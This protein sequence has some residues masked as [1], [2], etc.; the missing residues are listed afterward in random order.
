MDSL[1]RRGV[2][3]TVPG[4]V[5][6]ATLRFLK[7]N[8]LPDLTDGWVETQHKI[9]LRNFPPARHLVVWRDDCSSL[10]DAIRVSVAR[11]SID[12]VENFVENSLQPH[13]SAFLQ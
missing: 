12:P 9:L 13:S 6:V 2:N 7:L 5:D 1:H 10:K 11:F 8:A 3:R 4:L